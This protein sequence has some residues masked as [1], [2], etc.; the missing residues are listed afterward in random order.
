M[1]DGS[2]ALRLAIDLLHIPSRVRS[3]RT[4]ALPQDVL[5]LLEIAAGDAEITRQASEA[6]GRTQEVV[7]N[8]ATFFIEQ[9][10]LAPDSD[11]YRVL[12][13]NA[14]TT[15]GDL[16]RNMALLL[17]WLHP[18]MEHNGN[19]DRSLFAGRVTLAWENLKTAERRAAYDATRE[20]RGATTAKQRNRAKKGPQRAAGAHANNSHHVGSGERGAQPPNRLLRALLTLFGV[21]RH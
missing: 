17:R 14:Q 20:R 7:R 19:N 1:M 4:A 16:R 2:A 3:M 18:D 12:G 8:A 6:S 21:A 15:S 13:G 9:V 10:L 5:T 11:S